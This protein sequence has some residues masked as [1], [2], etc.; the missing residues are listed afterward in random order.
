MFSE[1]D[2]CILGVIWREGPMSGYGV[3]AHF[4]GSTTAAWS[5]STGTVYPALRR[6][7]E[8]GLLEAGEPSG[9]RRQELLTVTSK[10]AEVLRA[11]LTQVPSQL[12]SPTADPIRTRVHF[13]AALDSEARR[14]AIADY[15]SATAAALAALGAARPGSAKVERSERL[16]ARGAAM[17]LEARLAWLDLV[18]RELG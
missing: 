18:E 16:G 14:R 2:C 4:A 1:L 7:R 11:W 9:P 13:L 10:G 6:L 8:A 12:G 3:R 15:R 17:E 5:S